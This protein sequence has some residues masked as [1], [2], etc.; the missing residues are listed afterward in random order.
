MQPKTF[1]FMKIFY[2]ECLPFDY[3]WVYTIF[4]PNALWEG[5]EYVQNFN[6]IS[7]ISLYELFQKKVSKTNNMLDKLVYMK[8]ILGK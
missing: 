6:K 2:F 7:E 4:D 3:I 1:F 8:K 5:I